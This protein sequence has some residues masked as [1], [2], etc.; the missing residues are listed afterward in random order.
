[1]FG[2][3][4]L[5]DCS[6]SQNERDKVQLSPNSYAGL[7]IH[8]CRIFFFCLGGS[9]KRDLI[10]YVRL[11]HAQASTQQQQAVFVQIQAVD[12]PEVCQRKLNVPLLNTQ[13]ALLPW[14][15]NIL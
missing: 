6:W 1:M 2:R 15:R 3:G 5:W 13:Q 7:C 8:S 4:N 12:M 14:S 11:G 9:V 10:L